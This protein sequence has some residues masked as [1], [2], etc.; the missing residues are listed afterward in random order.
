MNEK[1]EMSNKK[2]GIPIFFF[3][4]NNRLI[5]NPN[6]ESISHTRLKIDKC[7]VICKLIAHL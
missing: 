4:K 3:K 1:D 6:Q 2:K 7:I 5:S